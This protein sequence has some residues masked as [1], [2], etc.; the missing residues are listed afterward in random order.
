MSLFNFVDNTVLSYKFSIN[1]EIRWVSLT[2]Y[3]IASVPWTAS[4]SSILSGMCVILVLGF[5]K[6]WSKPLKHCQLF[7]SLIGKFWQKFEAVSSIHLLLWMT[8]MISL[9]S[10]SLV[11]LSQP[12]SDNCKIHFGLLCNNAVALCFAGRTCR[13]GNMTQIIRKVTGNECKSYQDI[14]GKHYWTYI[15]RI[16]KLCFI[17]LNY[18]ILRS[19]R[20]NSNDEQ[21]ILSPYK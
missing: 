9:T 11:Y 2:A 14:Q 4:L 5:L 13:P 17:G 1:S 12:D 21:N 18:P 8:E 7:F 20:Q 16:S 10:D 6:I 19:S 15:L 3:R